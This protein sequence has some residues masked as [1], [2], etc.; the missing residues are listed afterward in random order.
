M[1][2]QIRLHL[3]RIM[4]NGNGL[5]VNSVVQTL[6]ISDWFPGAGLLLQMFRLK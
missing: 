5:R 6:C 3:L 1:R 4:A 2:S